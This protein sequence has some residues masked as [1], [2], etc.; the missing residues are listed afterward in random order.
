MA[1]RVWGI[2]L[3][4][5]ASCGM[6]AHD[7]QAPQAA[8]GFVGEPGDFGGGGSTFVGGGQPALPGAVF[9]A[10][11]ALKPVSGGTL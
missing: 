10:D 3:L 2:G 8:P 11:R 4:A 6:G 9:Q 7:D 5:L 1:K